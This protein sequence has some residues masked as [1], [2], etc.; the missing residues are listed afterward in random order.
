MQTFA[1]PEHGPEKVY[2][3]FRKRSCSIKNME[4][5]RECAGHPRASVQHGIFPWT[6]PLGILLTLKIFPA[7]SIRHKTAYK[8]DN[9]ARRS[10]RRRGGREPCAAEGL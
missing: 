10:L 4:H 7:K 2:S 9:I 5:D 6:I 8:A 1:G 3:G